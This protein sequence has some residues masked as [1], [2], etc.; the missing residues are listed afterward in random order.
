MKYFV[1]IFTTYFIA[2]QQKM[3][4]PAGG[5]DYPKVVE[6]KDSS[7]W[8]YQYKDSLPV[9]D[10]LKAIDFGRFFLHNFNEPNLS[11][12]PQEKEV[13]R[14]IYDEFSSEPF[15]INLTETNITVKRGIKGWA[16]PYY[17]QEKLSEHEQE[18]ESQSE[19]YFRVAERWK[20]DPL[21]AAYLDSLLKVFPDMNNPVAYQTLLN[22]TID[23]GPI[24]FQ[25][26]AQII[27]IT[28]K[29]FDSLVNLINASSYWSMERESDCE[30]IPADASSFTLEANT[31]YKYKIVGSAS[32]EN[33]YRNFTKACQE[34]VNHARLSN[35]I[36]LIW[37]GG[38]TIV[39]S[40]PEVQLSSP[41]E[42]K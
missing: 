35:K 6:V 39:D 23:Y 11:T 41:N 4:Y 28:R 2:C 7:F 3:E 10:S 19:R 42:K 29:T 25:Y 12:L 30:Y 8:I 1:V 32:C 21:R 26:S 16:Y 20:K 33:D 13:F 18:L 34:I 40:I 31:P 17:N 37:S 38:T 9:L 22:K 24:P 5:L 27:P 15:V 36:N 14:L